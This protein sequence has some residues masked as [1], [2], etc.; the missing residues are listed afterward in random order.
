[1]ALRLT[2]STIRRLAGLSLVTAL[3]ALLLVW[4]PSDVRA[5]IQATYYVSPAGSDSNTGTSL[6]QPFK[7]IAKARDAV[8]A[9]KGTMTGDIVVYVRA[10]DYYVDDTIAFDETDSGNNLHRIIY[11]NYDA[12]GSAR[13][14]GGRKL[15]GWS[16]Y[17]GTTYRTYVGTSWSFDALF[18][19]GESARIARY[20]NAGYNKIQS[21]D[22]TQPKKAFYYASGDVPAIA[23]I[24][25]LQVYV[26]P[27][28]HN[29]A[30]EILPVQAINRTNRKITLTQNQ[31]WDYLDTLKGGS[32]YFIQGAIELLDSPGEFYLDKAAGYLYYKPMHASD[33]GFD[34]DA[35]EII[36]PKVDKVLLLSGSSPTSRIHDI[37][38]DGLTVMVSNW[39]YEEMN[40]RRTGNIVIANADNIA[41][42]NNRILNSASNGV[43]LPNTD[44]QS[45]PQPSRA[46][47]VTV[48]GNYI[49]DVGDSGVV[50]VGTANTADFRLT[51]H[52]VSNNEIDRIARTSTNGAGVQLSNVAN[53]EVSY[54]KITN[55]THYGIEVKGS[56]WTNMPTTIEGVAV[57]NANHYNFNPGQND[58]IRYNDIS[59]VN[60]DSQDT[61]IIKTG[62]VYNLTI[63]HNVLHDSGKFG[64]QKGLYLDDVSDHNT[65]TNNIVYGLKGGTKIDYNVKGIGNT[66]ENNVA[67]ATG[68]A[69]GVQFNVIGDQP[70]R[71]NIM[72]HNII[73][74]ARVFYNFSSW[75]SNRVDTSDYNVFYSPTGTRTMSNIPGADTFAH[76]KTLYSNKYDQHTSTANPLFANA[77]NHD[78]TLQAGSPA[79]AKGIQSIDVG[80]VGLKND[81]VYADSPADLVLETS[82]VEPAPDPSFADDF[83][84]GFTDNWGALFGTP[85]ASANQAHSG[86]TSFLP[87]Q[88]QDEIYHLMDDETFGIL[89]VW[90][91]DQ[92]SD[93]T[94]K[95]RARVYSSS[96]A[97]NAMIGVV[98]YNST[99]KYSYLV[100]DQNW[101]ASSVN[102]TT[103]WHKFTFDFSSGT[104][105][106][107]SID[108][109][110]IGTSD[111]LTSFDE[112]HLGDNA[113]DGNTGN[114]YFDD[115]SLYDVF[116]QYEE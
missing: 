28:A 85:T 100:E 13:I 67:D 34:I 38:I 69:K 104:D 92:A 105:C 48:Y 52:L 102:R 96:V 32:R 47:N 65:V 36:A 86:A 10:G 7:T 97:E 20:P 35:Q 114:V 1:M 66:V 103:G 42:T 79:L 115:V 58:V 5:A 80:A 106:K 71:D 53:S 44:F 51:N 107:L 41:I 81:Y 17:S 24:S 60:Q 40:S 11:R 39:T 98:T 56:K 94:M 83:E 108:D 112:I 54:N 26:W 77:A 113:D 25:S 23:D 111:I 15:T 46:S 57:T 95:V 22:A 61:G 68:G 88:D 21:A 74:N 12:P 18:E 99:S 110:P 3:A 43:S 31:R 64:L 55:A 82:I 90:F 91:Y 50:L 19:N 73:F 8:R 49:H 101:I 78:Y 59:K 72:L 93:N 2:G 76:W 29:W 33:P 27:G 30:N 4:H 9:A 87:D 45:T 75:S 109:T 84:N 70:T 37:D 14:I 62:G 63:D 6:A 116:E 16:V 89:N